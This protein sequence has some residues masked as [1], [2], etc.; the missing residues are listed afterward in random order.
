MAIS[1]QFIS[2]QT[3]YYEAEI[4]QTTYNPIYPTLNLQQLN[5]IKLTASQSSYSPEPD[6]SAIEF[7]FQEATDFTAKHFKREDN[8][9]IAIV[10]DVWVFRQLAVEV[11]LT[12]HNLS[13][14]KIK[15]YIVD[16]TSYLNNRPLINGHLLLDVH[17][18]LLNT[19]PNKVIDSVNLMRENKQLSLTLFQR[20]SISIEGE[21]GFKISS[22]WYGKGERTF[23]VHAPFYGNDSNRFKAI[24]IK[25]ESETLPS[26]E[27]IQFISV[28]YE[29]EFGNVQS[30]PMEDLKIYLDRVYPPIF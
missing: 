25:T 7:Q 14:A 12:N 6:I 15:V 13:D 9:Y 22:I 20:V 27:V 28:D 30:T 4:P 21:Q 11:E 26:G 24:G 17:A 3:L 29:D 16:H 10:D 23:Y 8:R 18:N 5:K 19:T 2:A 1:S